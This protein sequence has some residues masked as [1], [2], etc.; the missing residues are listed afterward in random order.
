VL[1][2][3][4][5]AIVHACFAQAFFCLA[6]LVAVVTSRWWIDAPDLS[7]TITS[8]TGGRRLISLAAA[9]A[10]AI[11]VQLIVGAMMRHYQAGVAIPDFPL[12]Y[13]K[14]LPPVTTEQL[15]EAAWTR[16]QWDVTWH[17][18]VRSPANLT[19]GQ[20]WL[21]F[22][23][24]IGAVVVSVLLLWLIV[25]IV[26]TVELVVVRPF[27]EALFALLLGQLT[28]GV[29]TVLM[30]K[31]ADVASLHVAFGALLLMTTFVLLVR[32][33]RLYS[34]RWRTS[35]RGFEISNIKS[36]PDASLVPA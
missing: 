17:D 18:S 23:H 28:L 5:L 9:C 15:R 32:A 26:R 1:V 36:T 3:L 25:K 14:L 13:G 24:R 31:P 35:P 4:D 20:V 2:K 21:H 8:I 11:Y 6:A 12:N 10:I 19:L 30:R 27:A 29:F 34:P 16:W 33:M 7:D 22:G